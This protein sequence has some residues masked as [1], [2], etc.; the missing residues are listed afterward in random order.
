MVE[1]LAEWDLQEVGWL[2]LSKVPIV[3]AGIAVVCWLFASYGVYFDPNPGLGVMLNP[4]N[5]L[6]S[7]VLHSDWGHFAGNMRLWIPIGIVF[8]LLTN[9]REVFVV[10]V[11][12]HLMTQIVSNGMFRFG[13]GLSIAVF[14]IMAA[15]LVRSTGIAFQNYSKETVQWALAGMMVPILG[16]VFMVVVLIG[17]SPVGHLEH[18]F[19]ALFGAAIEAFYVFDDHDSDPSEAGDRRWLRT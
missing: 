3:V 5:Y 16:A 12:S 4:L 2:V 7:M 14:A 11:L 10:A 8:T 17:P 13:A 1:D 9:N 6:L 18:F 19:G 15:T